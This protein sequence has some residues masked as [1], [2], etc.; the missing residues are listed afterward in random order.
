M[1]F[2]GKQKSFCVLQLAKTKSIITV[3]CGFRTKYHT[4]PPTYNAI[5]E[6]NRKFKETGCLCAAKRTGR[7]GPSPETVD[8]L[9]ESFTRNPKKLTR[10][11]LFRPPR[12]PNLTSFDFFLWGYVRN[13]V[14]VPPLPTD[15]PE[16]RQR[17]VA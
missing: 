4:E 11:H 13:K 9:R 5:K 1:P 3:Q 14:Y 15:L 2:S 10:P 8:R 7:T 17:I 6:W 12:S 16:L